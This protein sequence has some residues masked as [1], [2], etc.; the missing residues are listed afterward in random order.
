MNGC[1]RGACPD[2]PYVC[3]RPRGVHHHCCGI[4][5]GETV[6]EG[7]GAVVEQLGEGKEGAAWREQKK[8]IKKKKQKKKRAK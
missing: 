3:F 5:A 4:R 2:T 6:E 1:S 8:C 7:E